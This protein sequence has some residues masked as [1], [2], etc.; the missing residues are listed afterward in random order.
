V[1]VTDASQTVRTTFNS[2]DW[3][4]YHLDVNNSTTQTLQAALRVIA[5]N[6]SGYVL[7][8]RTFQFNLPPGPTR[9]YTPPDFG[10]PAGAPSGTYTLD[11]LVYPYS[12][13]ASAAAT[14]PF[15]NSNAAVGGFELWKYSSL[16][17]SK[18][19][20]PFRVTHVN[21][22]P[23]HVPYY[24]QFQFL[25]PPNSACGE[26]SVAMAVNYYTD[27][28]D[29]PINP[30]YGVAN[31]IPVNGSYATLNP[32]TTEAYATDL[33]N[34]LTNIYHIGYAEIPHSA[35]TPANAASAVARIQN[36][37][38]Q[39]HPVIAWVSGTA[40]SRDYDGHWIVIRG[41]S[42]QTV[43]VNDPDNH[44]LNPGQNTLTLSAYE[45]AAE[46]AADT[47]GQ[48][49]PWGIIVNGNPH[50]SVTAG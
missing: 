22:Y 7:I 3:I 39:G 26:T 21:A 2:G 18:D 17:A 24:S 36:E 15:H 25:K 12:D 41:I 6:Q 31:L 14:Y 46:V 29:S 50:G 27:W 48:N 38:A 5:S 42:G 20:A 19:S 10:I 45:K 33:E 4:N 44:S 34:A 47:P 28:N 30:A 13:T 40:L 37:T 49:Q 43:Y 16:W 11:G 8:D 9:V 32:I 1:Y 35:G 23:L